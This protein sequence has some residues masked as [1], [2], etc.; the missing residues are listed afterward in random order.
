[1]R[2][3]HH[4]SAEGGEEVTY[5][6]LRPQVEEL[7]ARLTPAFIEDAVRALLRQ[8]ED[9]GGGINA[10]R[11]VKHLLGNPQSR[12]VEVLWAYDRLKPA[13]RSA[14]EQIPSLYYF[15]GD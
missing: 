4:K 2:A 9:V 10:F 13:L 3:E 15:E 11:L 8:G 1:M 12:D 7:Q 6:E 14:L 5:E